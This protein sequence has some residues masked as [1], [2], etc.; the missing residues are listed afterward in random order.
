MTEETKTLIGLFF[1]L[2]FVFS[3]SCGQADPGRDLG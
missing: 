1:A 2:A 3:A